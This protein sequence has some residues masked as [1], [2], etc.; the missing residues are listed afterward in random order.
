MTLQLLGLSVHALDHLVTHQNTSKILQTHSLVLC[1]SIVVRVGF[2]TEIRRIQIYCRCR[3]DFVKSHGFIG[4]R[5]GHFVIKGF[6][7][8]GFGKV[9]DHYLNRVERCHY[10]ATFFAQDGSCG[11]FQLFEFHNIGC[12][13]STNVLAKRINHLGIVSSSTQTRDSRH[14]RIVP[15]PNVFVVHQTNQLSFGQDCILEIQSRHFVHL[16]PV[17]IQGPQNPVVRLTSRFKFQGANGIVN[18]FQ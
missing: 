17:Q 16:G 2:G 15:T 13:C 9:G 6:P 8:H 1:Q 12:S 3:G 18:F 5:V 7:S 4:W 11:L 14:A 10:T